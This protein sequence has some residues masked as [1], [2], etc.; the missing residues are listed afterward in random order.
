MSQF[1]F[2][3]NIHFP[4]CIRIW[5]HPIWRKTLTHLDLFPHPNT[6]FSPLSSSYFKG[7]GVPL[8]WN[9]QANIL[10]IKQWSAGLKH[11]MHLKH[12]IRITRV[13]W[14]HDIVVNK[15]NNAVIKQL[16]E[17][18]VFS[19]L[20]LNKYFTSV[21]VH[22]WVRSPTAVQCYGF[23]L[24]G[25]IHLFIH[26]CHWSCLI[27]SFMGLNT[28]GRLNAL[29]LLAKW[30]SGGPVMGASLSTRGHVVVMQLVRCWSPRG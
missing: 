21:C 12:I 16:T 4:A 14:W 20:K 30:G 15:V 18:H 23:M 27:F 13:H 11:V 17:I 6:V 3:F 2:F 24:E 10:L 19:G 25:P 26:S 22:V 9:M 1:R 5:S 7:C 29:G 8:F 28:E